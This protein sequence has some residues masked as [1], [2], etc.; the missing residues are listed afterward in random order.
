MEV[1]SE[2][3]IEYGIELMWVLTNSGKSK[4]RVVELAAYI[5][6]NDKG[7]YSL[8]IFMLYLETTLRSLK[9]AT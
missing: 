6:E 5:L 4:D 9:S 7:E 2:A 8:V 3:Y 1:F